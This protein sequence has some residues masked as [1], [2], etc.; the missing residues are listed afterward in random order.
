MFEIT[1][2]YNKEVFCKCY[3]VYYKFLVNTM[4]KEQ[5]Y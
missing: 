2:E 3:K 1:T 4:L 5:F